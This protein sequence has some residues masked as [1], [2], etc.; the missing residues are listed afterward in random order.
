MFPLACQP[1]SIHVKDLTRFVAA[2]MDAIQV[3]KAHLIGYSL[4]GWILICLATDFPA[5]VDKL[6][7]VSSGGLSKG[8]PMLMRLI[9][10]PVVGEFLGA[11]IANQNFDK[12][13][14]EQRKNWP[15]ATVAADEL[16]R[17]KYDAKDWQV[18]TK[19]ILKLFCT[20]GNFFGLKESVYLPAVQ[21]LPS[22]KIPLL[23][24]WGRQD[25]LAPVE[26]T[27]VIATKSTHAQIEIFDGCRHDAMIEKPEIFNQLVL[28]FLKS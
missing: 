21:G 17:L 27:Q 18:M 13:L 4:G 5:Y 16:V 10:L 3:E 7:V 9:A 28:E 24:I 25:E 23:V 12:H 2:F 8:L 15:D 11:M 19:P 14:E 26:N 6:V 1:V 22:I 20:N